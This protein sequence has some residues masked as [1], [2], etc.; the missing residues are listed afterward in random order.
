[1]AITKPA[2]RQYVFSVQLSLT[3]LSAFA[4][5]LI[6]G[7]LPGFFAAALGL[8]LDEPAAYRYVL[9]I[10]ATLFLPAMFAVGLTRRQVDS[11][12][13][14]S[15]GQYGDS[16]RPTGLIIFMAAVVLLQ[17]V[18]QSAADIFFNVYL[19]KSLEMSTAA[20]GGLTGF[21]RLLAVPM[22]LLTP[23]LVSRWGIGRTI[24]RGILGMAV[25]MLPLALIPHWGAASFGFMGVV[26]LFTLTAPAFAI[27]QQEIVPPAWRSTMAG[28]ISMT[29][30]LGTAAVAFGGGYVITDLGYQTFFVAAAVLAAI[31]GLLFWG[32]TWVPR[33]VLLHEAKA[34][35]NL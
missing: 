16:P 7:L 5:S 35:Q 29:T 17:V 11:E 20:I 21:S 33:Y 15:R 3:P 27:A 2:E 24:T 10:A 13:P 1:M 8:S 31:G 6:G 4:G 28:A 9:F 22:A 19:D 30:G 23:L 14:H 26:A 12:Q 18:G 25:A 34:A 32:F